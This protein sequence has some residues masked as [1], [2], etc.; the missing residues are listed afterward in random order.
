[1]RYYRGNTYAIAW[2]T[3]DL[4]A[5]AFATFGF[6]AS[7]KAER[8]RMAGISSDIDFS[9]DFQDLRLERVE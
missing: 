8:I 9:Y 2:A 6:G 1:M 4:E 3:P 7:G 5:D